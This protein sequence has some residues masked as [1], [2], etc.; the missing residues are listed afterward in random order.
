MVES[1]DVNPRSLG[2]RSRGRN[3][4]GGA[5]G[6]GEEVERGLSTG[7]ADRR[8]DH[9]TRLG[10]LGHGQSTAGSHH[11]WPRAS[12]WRGNKEVMG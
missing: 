12:T 11:V 1:F 4:E 6:G 8:N 3:P 9:S 10:R 5:A 7:F 2:A